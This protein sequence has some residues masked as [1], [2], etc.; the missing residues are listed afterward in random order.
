MTI[1]AITPKPIAVLEL[2]PLR[3]FFR[4]IPELT[5]GELPSWLF[6]P[7][8][9]LFDRLEP[10]DRLDE[11]ADRESD[12]DA[13][14]PR[15]EF[16]PDELEP[17]APEFEPVEPELREL[18]L[19]EPPELDPP[20]VELAELEFLEPFELERE[21]FEPAPREPEFP[22]PE[23]EELEPEFEF[24][25]VLWPT[26]FACSR[27]RSP[28][29]KLIRSLPDRSTLPLNPSACITPAVVSLTKFWMSRQLLTTK[30]KMSEETA[31][32][33]TICSASIPCSL[34]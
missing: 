15:L 14:L 21:P 33:K 9:A 13:E 7:P 8:N 6:P 11:L 10:P 2:L 30:T 19:P 26:S 4:S 20:E 22:E 34:A 28:S 29:P 17:P 32:I 25:E 27:G 18:E 1:A 5:T 23:P 12:L 16:E 3:F 31:M 24:R